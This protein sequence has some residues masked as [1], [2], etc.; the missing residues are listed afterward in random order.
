M[1]EVCQWKDCVGYLYLVGFEWGSGRANRKWCACTGQ[2]EV[3][4]VVE[5]EGVYKFMCGWD[6]CCVLER[7]ALKTLKDNVNLTILPAD[8]GNA[9]VVLNTSDYKQKISS[10]LQDPAYRKV[11]KDPTDSIERKPRHCSKNHH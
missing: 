3:Q 10:F 8:K 11:T 6:Y 1:N 5:G 7:A 9:T 2:V 4:Q